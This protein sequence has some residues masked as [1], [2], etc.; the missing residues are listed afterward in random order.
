MRAG[1]A[2]SVAELIDALWG[3][4]PPNT[5]VKSLQSYVARARS[6]MGRDVLVAA[7]DGYQLTVTPEQVDLVQFERAL[8]SVSGLRAEGRIAETLSLLDEAIGLWRGEADTELP[9]SEAA[10]AESARLGELLASA[11]QDRLEARLA[12]GDA[13][14]AVA[15]GERLVAEAPL[16]E[17]R[18]GLL[19]TALFA[20]GRQAD[21]LRA[22]QR[23]RTV[24]IDELGIEPGASLRL[25]EQRI[26]EQDPS[27]LPLPLPPIDAPRQPTHR[28]AP[29]EL[30][31]GTVTF[32]MTD[33][34]GSTALW[35]RHPKEMESVLAR[36]DEL[37]ATAVASAGGVLL[38]HKGEGDSTMSV[39]TTAAAAVD[40]AIAA[41]RML[42]A[43]PWPEHCRVT[44]RAAVSTGEVELRDGDYFGPA[45]NRAARI[46]SIASGGQLLLGATTHALIADTV[47]DG[48]DLVS[49]GEHQLKGISRSEH[50][51]E[52]RTE[53]TSP[54]AADD[55]DDERPAPIPM[56]VPF[57]ALL[58]T[59]VLDNFAGRGP[60]LSVLAGA[61]EEATAGER[62]AVLLA[63]EPGIGKTRLAAQ[64]AAAAHARGAVVLYGR[65]DEDLAA[66]FQPFAEAIDQLLSTAVGDVSSRLGERPG[67][68]VRLSARLGLTVPS[69][70]PPITGD[71]ETERFAL[72]D[73]VTSM[74]SAIGADNG[75]VL[76]LDD[77]HWASRPTLLMLRHV[78]RKA[79]AARLLVIGTYRDTDIDRTHPLAELLADLR[80]EPG[81]ERVALTGLDVAE[82]EAFVAASAGHDLDE[83]SRALAARVQAETAGNPLFVGEVLR[84]LVEVGAVRRTGGRW[85]LDPATTTDLIPE[86]VRDVIGRRLTS[87]SPGV[88]EIAAWASVVGRDFRLNVLTAVAAMTEDDLLDLLDE[89]LDARLVEETGPDRYRFSHAVVRT[90]LYEEIRTSRRV[91]MHRSVA[92]AYESLVPDD[93][94]AL[95]H[96]FG[97]A[98]A[99]GEHQKAIR[100]AVAAAE[101]ASVARAFDEAS[102]LLRRAVELYDDSGAD[103]TADR[104]DLL[105]DLARAQ[106]L[107]GGDWAAT[108]AVVVKLARSLADGERLA[109]AALV[110]NKGWTSTSF[111]VDEAFVTLLE[112][113]L[114]LLPLDDSPIRA[115]ITGTLAVE[116]HYGGDTERITALTND[117]VAMCERLGGDAEL[118]FLTRYSRHVARQGWPDPEIVAESIADLEHCAALAGD[119]DDSPVVWLVGT[120]PYGLRWVA[121]RLGDAEVDI[122]PLEWGVGPMA[123]WAASFAHAGLALVRG[124]HDRAEAL[125]NEAFELGQE[126][127]E[128]DA[129]PT[130]GNQILF[131]RRQQGRN[132]EAIAL[133]REAIAAGGPGAVEWNTALALL[134]CEA[135]RVDEADEPYRIAAEAQPHRLWS[136]AYL[137]SSLTLAFAVAD[138]DDREVAAP[139]FDQLLPAADLAGMWI[140]VS[141]LGPV[142]LGLGRLAC[143]LGN[144]SEADDFL[145]RAVAWAREQRTVYQ[146]TE[147]LLYRAVNLLRRDLPGDRDLAAEFLAECRSIAHPLGFATIIGR[148]ATASASI[149]GD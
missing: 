132:D 95:A 121:R 59:T 77:L 65:C 14:W 32:L 37:I 70:D 106:R 1:R 29:N 64:A 149:N 18:W 22:Y 69:L 33:I 90:A 114:R 8:E 124:D 96:H 94:V 91:R 53:K 136:N 120:T 137:P 110:A 47:D 105:L 126:A 146:L 26:I 98:A 118:T 24:L 66:P 41:R 67:E 56:M 23:A 61:W 111:V 6:A 84:H 79:P 83:N 108:V 51:W 113:C 87:L 17:R 109:Q 138:R 139:L 63:G 11:K 116:L 134:L 89:L 2:A 102:V 42:V 54:T 144:H 74:L 21:A 7:T 10:R 45:V 36:H 112:D 25:I 103:N 133:I 68:L 125:A 119:L 99:A 12:A 107:A 140:T 85:Q 130:W 27:L 122:L 55:D 3:D 19:M 123:R 48:V 15:E 4:D 39:F 82:V 145:A 92:G 81:T 30:P 100:Y 50:V 73:A 141:L 35:D 43:E 115:R 49:L 20:A 5:A 72:F 57:P 34:E 148:A 38:K 131:L 16:R 78:L 142:T 129:F 62:R 147:G 128:E 127:D 13:E 60:E 86:G 58:G 101:L 135:G 44:A 88:N 52:L 40:A 9:A 31:S 143:C 80:R 117:A 76:V 71:P 104:C 28:M 97:E 93:L 46:R 75:V